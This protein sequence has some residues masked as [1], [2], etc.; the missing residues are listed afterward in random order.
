MGMTFDKFAR[1]SALRPAIR[2]ARLA[3]AVTADIAAP[4]AP[5]S[6]HSLRPTSE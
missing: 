1:V 4:P 2:R 3:S 6:R 5:G